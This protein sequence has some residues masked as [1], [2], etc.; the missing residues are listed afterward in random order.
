MLS[1]ARIG[2]AV[3]AIREAQGMTIEQL[4]A[5]SG[6]DRGNL[7]RMECGKAGWRIEHVAMVAD[8]MKSKASEIILMAETPDNDISAITSKILALPERKRKKLLEFLN[9]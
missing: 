5:L 7:S 2:G 3:R 6:I 4:A 1:R 9:E 8:A